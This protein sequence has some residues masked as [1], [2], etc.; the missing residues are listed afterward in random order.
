MET[1]CW[2]L[3]PAADPK[4]LGHQQPFPVDP[5]HPLGSL[6]NGAKVELL[7]KFLWGDGQKYFSYLLLFFFIFTF[8]CCLLETDLKFLPKC[9]FPQHSG[10]RNPKGN[11]PNQP[12]RAT[13]SVRFA[14]RARPQHCPQGP[15]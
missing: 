4:P 5:S 1:R 3:G 11:L 13:S 7:E 8:C 14:A 9:S 2:Q 15:F 12:S 6:S 10:A